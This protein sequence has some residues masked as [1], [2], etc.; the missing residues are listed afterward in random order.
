MK[1]RKQIA[2]YVTMLLLLHAT[3]G[4]EPTVT[5]KKI[6]LECEKGKFTAVQLASKK[7]TLCCGDKCVD[8]EVSK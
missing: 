8:I 6:E 5:K 7:V 1:T 2:V 3:R 4:A